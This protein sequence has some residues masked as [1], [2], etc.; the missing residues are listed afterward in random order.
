MLIF[1]ILKKH[2]ISNK[3]YTGLNDEHAARWRHR[4]QRIKLSLNIK[5]K[6]KE[7]EKNIG[8]TR[9]PRQKNPTQRY[10]TEIECALLCQTRRKKKWLVRQHAR[11]RLS[12]LARTAQLIELH[13]RRRSAQL[14]RRQGPTPRRAFRARSC[15]HLHTRDTEQP[16]LTPQ[17]TRVRSLPHR[18][19]RHSF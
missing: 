3:H 16:H 1:L 6:E 2:S 9:E 8:N 18:A 14:P 17:P 5:N 13:S 15:C 19:T 12:G 4:R 7:K 10:C 11:G